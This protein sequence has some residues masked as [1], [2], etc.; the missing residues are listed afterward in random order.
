MTSLESIARERAEAS[1]G[2]LLVLG[3]EDR[4]ALV[5]LEQEI[6]PEDPWTTGMIAQ[7][8]SS[9][10]S[11]YFGVCVNDD[12]VA[13]PILCGY[14]GI[15][16]GIDAD[17]MTMGVLPD[18]RGRG[19]GRVLM[20]ALIDV[21]RRWGSERVFLEVR[22]SNAAAISLYEHSGFEV[23]GRTKAYFRNP[24][25]DALNMRLIVR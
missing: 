4:Q 23:V 8:L 2:Q 5:T 3:I 7:E 9:G 21:A 1:G 16:L 6:F 17:V 10:R 19:L 25:E 20:D 18:F 14:A 12:A 13:A 15:A 24:R 22:E 11:V